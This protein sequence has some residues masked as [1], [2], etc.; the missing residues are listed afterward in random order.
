MTA[1]SE[2]AFLAI[3]ALDGRLSGHPL[4]EAWSCRRRLRAT[5]EAAALDGI[6]VDAD[7]LVSLLIGVADLRK[8]YGA[9][10]AAL[11]LYERVGNPTEAAETILWHLTDPSLCGV[12]AAVNVA[13]KGGLPRSWAHG[14]FP[15]VLC[16]VGITESVLIGISP[17]A[18][19]DALNDG[20]VR[21]RRELD[22]LTLNW[23][24]W[25]R[26]LG[27]R[28]STSRHMQ[29][30]AATVGMTAAT[31]AGIARLFSMTSRGAAFIL[32]ELAGLGI[33]RE[34]S[35]RETWQVYLADDMPCDVERGAVPPRPEV[36]VPDLG[37]MFADL[38]RATAA[39]AKRLASDAVW[40]HHGS[41]MRQGE[42]G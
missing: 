22:K 40:L 36:E 24:R 38:E 12:C 28:R 11:A 15:A 17:L 10:S 27:R 26:L 34:A 41:G 16:Q 7:R 33:L 32:E 35:G 21:G 19:P 14:A 23:N 37:G 1:P 2:R 8:D 4:A 6:R 13:V 39:V 25:M 9:E 42:G 31:P 5:V 18:G 30:L 20:A 29:V 3:G